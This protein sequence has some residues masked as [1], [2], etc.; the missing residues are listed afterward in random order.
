M[1]PARTVERT[2]T[3]N[4]GKSRTRSA[5]RP[6]RTRVCCLLGP[7]PNAASIGCPRTRSA[8][9]RVRREFFWGHR[10]GAD[11]LP[12]QAHPF[13]E[14]PHLRRLTAD[15]RQSLDALAGFVHRAS[16]LAGELLADKITM[17]SQIAHRAAD[18]P[19]SQAIEAT[20]AEGSDIALH[21]GAS[22]TSNLS[23]LVAA[24]AAV[25]KPE[26][27]HLAA[28][29][30]LGVGVAFGLDDL[31]LFLGQLNP[32]PCHRESLGE[33]DQPGLPPW[34]YSVGSPTE[35]SHSTPR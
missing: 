20:V 30:L 22:Q 12:L 29:V 31:L 24:E 27:K 26:H 17:G 3:G 8:R 10:N 7:L 5:P 28:D 16:G 14:L 15:A 2:T 35:M 19:L 23:S 33:Q 25:Q 13:E 18:A 1:L 6:R 11:T 9:G 34:F 21:G 4:T 32:K